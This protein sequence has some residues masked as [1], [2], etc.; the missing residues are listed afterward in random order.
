MSSENIT[1]NSVLKTQR[2]EIEKAIGEYE[3]QCGLPKMID[4]PEA[5]NLLEVPLEELRRKN[6]GELYEMCMM[7]KKHVLY[8]QRVLNKKHAWENWARSK[9][10][11]LAAYNITLI[12]NEYGF[13]E[14]VLMARHN[15]ELCRLL[16]AF[17]RRVSMEKE[18]L[19]SLPK[20]IEGV[21]DTIRD[22]AYNKGRR[23]D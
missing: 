14:R 22:I 2:E 1:E 16:Q 3:R 6:P 8:I 12:G 5:A 21:A 9:I 15:S 13:N 23:N 20:Y 19:Y 4:N 10:D 18:T 7:M 17:L 11:E